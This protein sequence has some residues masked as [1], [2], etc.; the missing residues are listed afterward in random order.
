LTGQKIE[1]K[2]NVLVESARIAR[3]DCKDLK[4]LKVE[5]FDGVVVP[6]G[7]GVAKNLSDYA[8]KKA[9]FSID[10]EVARILKEFNEN[11]KPIGLSC[12]APIFAAKLFENY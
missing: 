6:G 2:R 4:E 3:G 8:D 7:F 10:P 5:S 9:D 1:E 12:I 11:K